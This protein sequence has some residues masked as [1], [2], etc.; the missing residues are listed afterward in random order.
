MPHKLQ[1]PLAV[2]SGRLQYLAEVAQSPNA[3]EGNDVGEVHTPPSSPS[4]VATVDHASLAMCGESCLRNP[5]RGNPHGGV[6]EGR[7]RWCCHGRPKRAR[8]WKRPIQPRNAY[9]A[10]AS[11]LLGCNHQMKH[12]DFLI[13]FFGTRRSVVQIH[14]PRPFYPPSNSTTS[15]CFPWCGWFVFWL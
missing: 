4:L 14:S 3:R 8:S 6:C 2:L 10:L 7:G 5:L 11:L 15:C 12:L 1:M 9:S 13:A